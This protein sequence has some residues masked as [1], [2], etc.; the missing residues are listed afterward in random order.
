MDIDVYIFAA[1]TFTFHDINFVFSVL[2]KKPKC[3]PQT[4]AFGHNCPAF[5]I[6]I[7]KGVDTPDAG[8]EVIEVYGV[9]FNI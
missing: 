7:S 1:L 6:A 5:K 8:G 2:T 9:V 3:G 4:F